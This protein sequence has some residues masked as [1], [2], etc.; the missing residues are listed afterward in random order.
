MVKM[1]RKTGKTFNEYVGLNVQ[2]ALLWSEL[3]RNGPLTIS[4]LAVV[5]KCSRPTVYKY[6]H[7]FKER[8]LVN[9][10]KKG[11]RRLFEPSSLNA[12]ERWH[13][14]R[15]RHGPKDALEKNNEKKEGGDV[16]IYRGRE[17]SRVWEMVLDE[18][19]K[20]GIFYR[21]DGYGKGISVA[22]HIPQDNYARIEAKKM[23]R[24]VITNE[25]LR[26]SSYKKRIECAS[27]MLPLSAGEFEQGVTH[28]LF[29]EKM[30]MIDVKNKI[31]FVIHNKNIVEYHRELFKWTYRQLPE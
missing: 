10:H 19:P 8:G 6:L 24:F 29:G 1:K 3:L 13:A 22:E 4:Q 11:K 25:F 28:I 2:E 9:T 12:V 17:L 27:R 31:A 14:S 18:T 7:V 30:A 20:K 5:S 21:Y 23:E 15:Q 26:K 16:Q